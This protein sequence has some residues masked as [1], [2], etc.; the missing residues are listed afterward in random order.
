MIFDSQPSPVLTAFVQSDRNVGGLRINTGEDD[1]AIYLNGEKYRRVT[2]RGRLLIYLYPKTYRVRAEKAGFRPTQEQAV[3]VKKGEQVSLDF[4]FDPLPTTATLR[5]R[6][7]VPGGQVL[8]DGNGVGV[9][10]S[11]GTLSFSNI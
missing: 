2:R 10:G 3:D 7:G 9:I 11:E 6:D 8:L 5:I 1:V 4:T